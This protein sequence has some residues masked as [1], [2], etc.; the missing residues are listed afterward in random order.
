MSG[1]INSVGARGG[2]VGSDVY[3]AGHVIQVVSDTKND[4]GS[5]SLTG[6]SGTIEKVHDAGGNEEWKGTINNVDSSNDVLV[7]MTF[8][9]RMYIA[10]GVTYVR[11]GFGIYRDA[12]LIL[13]SDGNDFQYWHQHAVT[14]IDDSKFITLQILDTSPTAGT[15]I[16]Y[17][18]Y[19]VDYGPL[20]IHSGSNNLPFICT[21]MEIQR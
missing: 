17:L 4:E 21:M 2:I 20:W 6:S 12:A 18:G 3:P 11:G 9:G 10:S 7:I 5:A 16:Y 13:E 1:I 19:K 15:N 14:G 8:I